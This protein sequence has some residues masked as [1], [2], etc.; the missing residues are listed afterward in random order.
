MKTLFIHIS[1]A[2]HLGLGI[3]GHYCVTRVHCLS[4]QGRACPLILRHREPENL[5][6]QNT[7]FALV[8]V[9]IVIFVDISFSKNAIQPKSVSCCLL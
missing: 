4:C 5:T 6:R 8:S 9:N 7:P 3:N 1:D 2:V